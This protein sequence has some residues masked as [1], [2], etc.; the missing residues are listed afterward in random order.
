[1]TQAIDDRLLTD[2]ALALTALRSWFFELGERHAQLDVSLIDELLER[3]EQETGEHL[4][5]P[6][7][8]GTHPPGWV[9]RIPRFRAWMT[10]GRSITILYLGSVDR[11][12]AKLAEHS[13]PVAV[14]VA[15]G[16][17]GLC[18]VNAAHVTSLEPAL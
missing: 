8:P 2:M 17:P 1:M 11:L 9:T 4:N 13:G 15:G 16:E 14:E 7:P 5:L 12:F 6:L 3:Y 10:D 18:F